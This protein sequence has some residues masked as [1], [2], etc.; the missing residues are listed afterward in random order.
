MMI[1][2]TGGLPHEIR[3]SPDP[4]VT[5]VNDFHALLIA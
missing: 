3:W 1:A 5:D 2:G 4:A